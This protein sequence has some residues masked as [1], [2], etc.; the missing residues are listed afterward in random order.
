MN[1][2]GKIVLAIKTCRIDFF[3]KIL[4]HLS[5]NSF[6]KPKPLNF[7]ST[8]KKGICTISLFCP[9]QDTIEIAPAKS[10]VSVSANNRKALESSKDE[11]LILI[12]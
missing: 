3:R 4:R 9:G 12:K 1:G 6:D 5:I 8:N 2:C 11:K 10:P 7:F